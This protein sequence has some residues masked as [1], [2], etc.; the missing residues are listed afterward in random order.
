MY[1]LVGMLGVGLLCNL[2]VRPVNPKHF[3]SDEEL[4]Q[5]K[6]LASERA[7][8]EAQHEMG[9]HT[10]HRS[11]TVL[12]TLAWLAVGLPLAWGVYRTVLSVAKFFH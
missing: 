1:I 12:V 9:T 5:E 10:Y 6:R 8:E 3:M 11:S 4:A 2:L 7:Q